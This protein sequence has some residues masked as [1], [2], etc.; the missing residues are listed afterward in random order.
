M[1]LVVEA[2]YENMSRRAAQMIA[3]QLR[4]KPNSVIGLATGS[5]PEGIYE[6]LIRMHREEGLS[7]KQAR[8][9]N[10]DEYKGLSPDDSQSY[11]YFLR[12]KFLD[13]IDADE[14]NVHLVKGRGFQPDEYE[15]LINSFGG[16]DLQLLGIGSNGHLGFNE[17]NTS[18]KSLTHEVKLHQK[19]KQD[20]GDGRF[21]KSADDVPE[22]AYTMGLGTII[23][24]AKKVI[25]V[26]GDRAGT[27]KK[28]RL[29][30]EL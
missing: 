27:G 3:A 29:L 10:L 24:K 5:T 22:R 9:V 7:F 15:R 12:T 13:H 21:F 4:V 17:P 26:A 28:L 16:I 23:N 20:N 8:F 6:E 25:L 1:L 18:S 11:Q 30:Q 19:T 14:K 2:N